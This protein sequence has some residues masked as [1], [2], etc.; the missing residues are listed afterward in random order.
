MSKTCSCGKSIKD[1]YKMCF[2]CSKTKSINNVNLPLQNKKLNVVYKKNLELPT[3]DELLNRKSKEGDKY[4]C[5]SSEC[6]NILTAGKN[7]KESN[8][9]W[10]YPCYLENMKDTYTPVKKLNYDDDDF[11]D[12]DNE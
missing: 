11:I 8:Y 6:G 3:L 7:Y 9:R 12:S 2:N 5:C 10:C 4:K 1:T